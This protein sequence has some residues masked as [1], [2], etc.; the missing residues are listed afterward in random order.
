ML[1]RRMTYLGGKARNTSGIK[2]NAGDSTP[3]SLGT[4]TQPIHNWTAVTELARTTGKPTP[5]SS[6]E[7]RDKYHLGGEARTTS[8]RRAGPLHP[9]VS[10]PPSLGQVVPVHDQVAK[11]KV[12]L[13]LYDSPRSSSSLGIRVF[14]SPWDILWSSPLSRPAPS[15]LMSA[16][17]TMITTSLYPVDESMLQDDQLHVAGMPWLLIIAI[18]SGVGMDNQ[19]PG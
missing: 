19:L 10:T 6:A 17:S 7:T 11:T 13:L 5:S 8:P 9:G 2:V 16:C 18:F 15:V 1:Q 12:E 14:P 3:P 4:S